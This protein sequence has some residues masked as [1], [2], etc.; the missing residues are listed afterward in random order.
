MLEINNKTD[1]QIDENL[2]SRVVEKFL[3]E[4][5]RLNY[6]VSLAIVGPE[7]MQNL[8]RNYRGKDKVTDVLSFENNLEEVDFPTP[9][10]MA[11]QLGEIVICFK[12]IVDQS[13]KYSDNVEEEF[14]FI[15]VHGLFHLLGYEDSTEKGR[16]EMDRLGKAFIQGLSPLK[17]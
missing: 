12:R 6:E 13:K 2:I 3:T 10:K 5:D 16:L 9:D 14:V 8:N 1:Y 4:Y 15:L 11:K 17:H 7:E